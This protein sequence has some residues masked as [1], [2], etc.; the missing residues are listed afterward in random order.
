MSA[1]QTRV[2]PRQF[3]LL[4]KLA[5]TVSTHGA[6][7]A[8]ATTFEVNG[9]DGK[10]SKYYN[11]WY[12]AFTTG[13]AI[14]QIRRILNH[15]INATCVVDSPWSGGVVPAS[16]NS[17]ALFQALT[18]Q[19]TD[20]MALAAGSTANII[21]LADSQGAV[22]LD[23]WYNGLDIEVISGIG[24]RG[25]HPGERRRILDYVG[26]TRL[27]TL[28]A[29]ISPVVDNTSRV[30]IQ[31]HLYHPLTSFDMVSAPAAGGV[32]RYSTL[33]GGMAWSPLNKTDQLDL[34]QQFA[35]P[36]YLELAMDTADGELAISRWE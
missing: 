9:A 31:G 10:A 13:P 22:T 33:P 25:E 2:N 21:A 15:T 14:T 32:F 30:R 7:A 29:P 24:K 36:R 26:S 34:S 4:I 12:V 17:Y 11:G 20:I 16:G 5:P 6:G 8:T 27:C 1:G 18:S 3:R 28:S 35:G 19:P 23:D